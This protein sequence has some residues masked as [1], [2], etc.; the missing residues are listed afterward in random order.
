M[1]LKHEL[2]IM[3]YLNS[4][5]DIDE[6]ARVVNTNPSTIK[7]WLKRDDVKEYMNDVLNDAAKAT[8][9][10]QIYVLNGYKELFETN[11]ELI[12]NDKGISR[13]K[14]AGTS[15]AALDSIVKMLGW[16]QSPDTQVNI[17]NN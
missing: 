11:K 5:G 3:T 6:A 12:T 8:G 16:Q 9:I 2:S 17:T 15:R 7:R 1:N 14:D 13:M 4:G 10:N